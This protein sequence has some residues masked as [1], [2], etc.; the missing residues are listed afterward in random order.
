MEKF[1][2]LFIYY[3]I[4]TQEFVIHLQ[5]FSVWHEIFELYTF[6][7]VLFNLSFW[8]TT[9]YCNSCS[10]IHEYRN[11]GG[12]TVY[13]RLLENKIHIGLFRNFIVIPVSISR[14]AIIPTFVSHSAVT[15][16]PILP[17]LFYWYITL[18]VVVST[19]ITCCTLMWVVLRKGVPR[20]VTMF[21]SVLLIC[22][23]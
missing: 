15:P 8:W 7:H 2:Y 22:C 20:G 19:I 6:Y 14:F 11:V 10:S 17:A 3:V 23:Q 16:N 4:F 9:H 5:L 12:F 1:I 13:L 18:C 21:E